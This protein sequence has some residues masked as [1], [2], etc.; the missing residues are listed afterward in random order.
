ME[1][2]LA[3][4]LLHRTHGND[5]GTIF[6]Q[7]GSFSLAEYESTKDTLRELEKEENEVDE[8]EKEAC[9]LAKLLLGEQLSEVE[10][11]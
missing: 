4:F 11:T 2:N 7:L 10:S 8:E 5:M 9:K 1:E 3:R 6:A